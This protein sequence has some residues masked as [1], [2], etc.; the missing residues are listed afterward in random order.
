MGS[1]MANQHQ[2]GEY[3]MSIKQSRRQRPGGFFV[4]GDGTERRK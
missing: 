4:V 3:I 2:E 1:A